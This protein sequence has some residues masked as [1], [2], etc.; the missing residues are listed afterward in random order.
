MLTGLLVILIIL[1]L[2]GYLDVTGLALPDLTLF[3]LNGQTITLLNLLM[4]FIIMAVL[5]VLPSPIREIAGVIFFLWILSV[6][7]ILAFAGLSSLLILAIIIGIVIAL[8][9]R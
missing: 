1:W 5:G 4:F 3:V 9:S 8:F 6:L 2:L 7:G